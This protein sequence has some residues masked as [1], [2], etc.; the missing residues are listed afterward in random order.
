MSNRSDLKIIA[1]QIEREIG[2]KVHVQNG[3]GTMGA[4]YY[5]VI[6]GKAG[7]AF[8]L[9][10]TAAEAVKTLEGVQIGLRIAGGK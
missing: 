3:S 8:K 5:L 10:K 2:Q 1:G 7:S 6:D 9:G 4:S